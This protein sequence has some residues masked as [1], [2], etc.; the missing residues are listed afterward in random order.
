MG[1]VYA[2]IELVNATDL[3]FVRRNYIDRDEVRS[4]R[5]RAMVDTGAVTMAINENI[6]EY[7]QLPVVDKKRYSLANGQ[8]ISCDLVF[9]LE[10]RFS[11]RVAR[12]TA[13]VLPED[14]EPLIGVI[15]LEEMDVI[16]HPLR[17]ELIV[18]PEHPDY[19]VGKLKGF[20]R[21]FP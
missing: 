7:L 6:Q 1:Q 2:E 3:E 19:A 4:I 17:E 16:I 11:N 12:C 18:N 14:S 21:E 10:V 20:R 9:P 15:P 5:V 13:I 8:S